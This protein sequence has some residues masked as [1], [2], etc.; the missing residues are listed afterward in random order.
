MKVDQHNT[1]TEC[2]KR[3]H[4]LCIGY[5]VKFDQD[6]KIHEVSVFA[7]Q[8]NRTPAPLGVLRFAA[9][10]WNVFFHSIY[11]KWE[12]MYYPAMDDTEGVD[13]I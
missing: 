11:R 1:E 12:D 9:D 10:E 13:D 6:T 8:N 3:R 2:W 4:D 7:V 5:K